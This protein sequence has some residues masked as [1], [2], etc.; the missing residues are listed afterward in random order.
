MET[1]TTA[2]EEAV[3]AAYSS[4]TVTLEE[5]GRVVELRKITFADSD[6]LSHFFG[7][8]LEQ[9]LPLKFDAKGNEVPDD[10]IDKSLMIKAV[11]KSIG[12]DP[13][14]A[15]SWCASTSDMTAK[16]I[17]KLGAGD[18][19]QLLEACSHFN[20]NNVARFFQHEI[21]MVQSIQPIG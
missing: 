9:L 18:G 17:G 21:A 11:F 8:Y 10:K 2:R 20:S 16:E 5:C 3:E 15:I 13:K 4:E 14:A 19:T 12:S 6:K 7:G 1:E